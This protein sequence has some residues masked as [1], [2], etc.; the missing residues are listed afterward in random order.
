MIVRPARLIREVLLAEGIAQSLPQFPWR[1]LT[2]KMPDGVGTLDDTIAVVE[3]EDIEVGR[4]ISDSNYR[5]DPHVQIIVRAIGLS[6]SYDKLREITDFLDGIHDYNVVVDG[7]E[8]FVI[9]VKRTTNIQFNGADGTGRRYIHTIEY[10]LN[11][12]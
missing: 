8:Y 2:V 11:F 12:Q 7:D 4:Y 6:R 3:R 9:G 5:V 10:D 1:C